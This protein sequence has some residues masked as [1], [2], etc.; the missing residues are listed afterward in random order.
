MESPE[1]SFTDWA[2]SMK[3]SDEHTQ[4]VLNTLFNKIEKGETSQSD[5]N[6]LFKEYDLG[7]KSRNDVKLGRLIN[8]LLPG[9]YT[10]KDIEEFTNKFKASLS[11]QGEYFEEV[12]GEDIN[13]WYQS[14]N[15]K[16]MSGNLGNSCMA[17]K[18]GLF[19][20]YIDN[21][22]VC[23]LLILVEDDKLVG[24]ALVWKLESISTNKKETAQNWFMDRQYTIK[25]SDSE[26]FKDSAREKGWYYKTYNNHHSL[27]SVIVDGEE[28][29][30]EMKVLVKSINYKKYPYMDTFKR[31][32]PNDGTLYNDDD[33][34]ADYE[35]QYILN[36][37][38]GGYE[39]IQSGVYSEW[40]DRR[41][42]ED[43]W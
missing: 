36:D 12:S 27:D 32:D 21:P 38:S 3:L 26:K 30:A 31:F 11:K 1:K 4:S 10:P 20:I 5:V 35:G 23:K 16:E 8:A 25:D 19:D 14:K 15:Y 43:V 39:S 33:M 34:D 28:K 22:D 6:H 18:V 29:R 37:T 7:T 42:P 41:I 24:R 2:K 9:K 17:H 13:Y 40:Y